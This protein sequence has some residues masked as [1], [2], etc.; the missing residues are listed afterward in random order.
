MQLLIGL[1]YHLGFLNNCSTAIHKPIKITQKP[2]LRIHKTP[3]D[4][5]LL[6]LSFL[7]LFNTA[8]RLTRSPGINN[9]LFALIGATLGQVYFKATCLLSDNEALL[10]LERTDL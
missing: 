7:F 4:Y 1:R 5:V 9:E 6:L 8:C 10:L 3:P 2:Y